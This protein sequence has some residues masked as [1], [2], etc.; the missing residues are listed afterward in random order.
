MNQKEFGVYFLN[1]FDF[2][3]IQRYEKQDYNSIIWNNFSRMIIRTI[4]IL[5]EVQMIIF[6]NNK[7]IIGCMM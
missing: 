1:I 7:E 6:R 3:K 5:V 2:I 4:T